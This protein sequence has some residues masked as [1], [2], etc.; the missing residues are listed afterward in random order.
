MSRLLNTA[1]IGTALAFSVAIT[2]VALRAE[3]HPA[4]YHDKDHNDDHEW[5]KNED[6]AYRIWV[7]DNH[8]K[9]QNFNKLKEEDQSSYWRWRHEHSDADLHINIR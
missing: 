5:N 7:R 1:L 2:P 4:R 3:D 6:Q 9:Y 8:R